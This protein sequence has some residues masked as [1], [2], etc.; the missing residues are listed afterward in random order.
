MNPN[1]T[2]S[3]ILGQIRLVGVEEEV[4]ESDNTLDSIDL[5][6]SAEE[7]LNNADHGIQNKNEDENEILND[8]RVEPSDDES[9]DEDT[10]IDSFYL[11]S[12]GSVQL[13]LFRR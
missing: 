10:I 12:K 8:P 4:L 2:E 5:L 13:G 6:P 11:I 3:S 1:N 7:I 9:T